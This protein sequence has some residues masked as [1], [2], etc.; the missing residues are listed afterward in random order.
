M[1]YSF[2]VLNSSNK[3][4]TNN[5]SIRARKLLAK[6]RAPTRDTLKER[7]RST[8]KANYWSKRFKSKTKNCRWKS[9]EH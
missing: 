2:Q 9:A 5:K 4:C 7:Q 3:E 8:V 1:K 6:L